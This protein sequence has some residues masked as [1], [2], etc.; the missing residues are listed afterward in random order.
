VWSAIC[1]SENDRPGNEF[2]QV[3]G[4]MAVAVSQSWDA[5]DVHL[6]F[7]HLCGGVVIASA[8]VLR[9]Q[10][11]ATGAAIGDGKGGKLKEKRCQD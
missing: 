3:D 1:L 8:E 4:P 7:P 5:T 11:I 9:L 10:A 6:D 2:S